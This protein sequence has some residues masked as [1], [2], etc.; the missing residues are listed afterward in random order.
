M[1]SGSSRA[2]RRWCAATIVLVLSWSLPG[3]GHARVSPMEIVKYQLRKPNFLIVVESAES[4][5]GIPGEN[6]AR[7]NEVGADCQNGD[8]SCRLYGQA[9]RCEFSGMGAQG[10]Q[11]D[12]VSN[13]TATRTE[14][15]SQTLVT[16]TVT[17]TQT[18][19]GTLTANTSAVITSTSSG[20]SATAI[21]TGTATAIT[22]QSATGTMTTSP[23]GTETA[24]QTGTQTVTN[25]Q[26]NTQT[27][28]QP[29]TSSQTNTQTA[30]QTQTA[31][32][33]GSQTATQTVT[34]S[35]TNTQSATQT[36][37]ASQTNTQS[38]TQTQSA[39]QTNTQTAT[40]TSTKSQTN[41]QTATQTQTASQTSTQTGTATYTTSQTS[42]TTG[43]T[44]ANKV[45]TDTNI[46]GYWSLD[47]NG[48]PYADTSGNNNDGTATGPPTVGSY[49]VAGKSAAFSSTAQYITVNMSQPAS[50]FSIAAWVQVSDLNNI[51]RNT[52]VAFTPGQSDNLGGG[53]M[54]LFLDKG[55][56][57]S[58]KGSV[59]FDNNAPFVTTTTATGTA[60][61]TLRT[62]A[63]GYGVQLTNAGNGFASQ[64]WI[65]IVAT[66]SAPTWTIYYWSDAR[67]KDGTGGNCG[68]TG[69]S[70]SYYTSTSVS[71]SSA[72]F[73]VGST[74][75]CFGAGC[76]GSTI[77][78]GL[79]GSL[80]E[81]RMWDRAV[82]APEAANL[83]TCN[84][85]SCPVTTATLTT[86]NTETLTPTVTTSGTATHTATQT[87]TTSKTQS[88]TYT[89]TGTSTYSQSGTYTNTGTSTVS[90][91]GTYTNTGTSTVSQTGTYT[92]T[93]TSTVFADGDV[94]EHRDE[95]AHFNWDLHE[96]RDEYVFADR[97][98]HVHGFLVLNWHR[99][100]HQD[101][102]GAR[103]DG[104]EH[105]GCEPVSQC[106]GNRHRDRCRA[107][108]CELH[109]CHDGDS[110]GDRYLHDQ[111][112]GYDDLCAV[113]SARPQCLFGC[114]L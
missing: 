79:V 110:D 5:Q 112:Y 76:T 37:S 113:P 50:P 36:Q 30:T 35:Q 60:T 63:S 90:Q 51:Q 81:V 78:N 47:E 70:T 74:Q 114:Q 103:S 66:V 58:P 42:H 91:T 14:T 101:F 107:R 55:P 19:T 69:T 62:V 67:A 24:T 41:T 93:G 10:Y 82:T 23:T 48:G 45:G 9:G 12:Y 61:N 15:Q 75:W 16:S 73:P 84:Y 86:T 3:S 52:I 96:H 100:G 102:H 22:S 33:S 26:T 109:Q 21:A 2:F 68:T 105:V 29:I 1:T 108:G 53:G 57:S 85:V 106:D 44:T 92:N 4:M 38:A 104:H 97:D 7:F 18:A 56:G 49:Q 31:G 80:D 59:V 87:Y 20:A 43:H 25:S 8:R 72:N 83:C 95:H 98:V 77:V 32:Q 39:S 99:D 13:G 6:P 94:H 40:Q 71:A 54:R 17:V 89:N 34:T 64:N 111:R 65:F 88:G 46:R 28:T 11:F 27:G